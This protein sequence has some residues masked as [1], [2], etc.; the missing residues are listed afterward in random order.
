M[1]SHP[2]GAPRAASAP[3]RVLI[4]LT[5]LGVLCTPISAA[6]ADDALLGGGDEASAALI[7]TGE[8]ESAA[9]LGLALERAGARA[10]VLDS[11]AIGLRTRGGLRD[12]EAVSLD[13]GAF[14]LAF[15]TGDVVV[16]PGFTGRDDLGRMTLL[17]RGGSDLTALFIGAEL[18]GRC[19]LVKDVDGLY[20]GDPNCT[21]SPAQHRYIRA[22]WDELARVG[23]VVVQRKAVVFAKQHGIRFRIAAIGRGGTEIGPGPNVFERVA[24]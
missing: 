15:G 20:D 22:S 23:E 4:Q 16:V 14:K 10:H 11:A 2:L 6:A 9:L 17:G 3:S 5:L 1:H 18:G 24:S 13:V 8:L 19:R 12:A 21:K 7:G